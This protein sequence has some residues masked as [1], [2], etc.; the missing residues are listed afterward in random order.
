MSFDLPLHVETAGREPGDGVPVFLLLH[1][2]GA[3]SFTWRSWVSELSARGHVVLVDMKGFGAAP[4]PDDG[5]YQPTVQA[6]LVHRLIA[7]RDL[8]RV[9]LCGHSL[10]GGVSLLTAI[11]L[12]DES[13][14][15]GTPQRLERLVIVSGAAYR[16]RLPP[17]VAMARR[18]RLS[19]GL[20][21]LLGPRRV[22]RYVLRT[23]VHDAEAVTSMQVEGYADPLRTKAARRAL[24]W[25][26]AQI[27]PPDLDDLAARFPE[28]DVPTL[29]L[30]GR[31]D[32]VVP[33]WV[34]ERLAQELSRAELHVMED[35]GHLPQEE[36]PQATLDL[37]RTFLD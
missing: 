6:E 16:Q 20:L 36:H 30:W 10:G 18:P 37:V 15:R 5:R 31:Q 32:R 12:L 24:L 11:R 7:Q 19:A 8:R 29:L 1:G 9:T 13:R 14:E 33:L 2:F 25:A 4:K 28:I 26:A 27:V 22:I 21:G 35:C 23:I 3:S 17:F 34:G